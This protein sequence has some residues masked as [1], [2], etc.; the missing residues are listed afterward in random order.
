MRKKTILFVLL[1]SIFLSGCPS[2]PSEQSEQQ[3][4]TDVCIALCQQAVAEA[5]DLSDGPCLSNEAIEDWV[6]D[7]AHSP[8][9]DIDNLPE[10]QCSAFRDKTAN[11]FV[12][13]DESCKVIQF[14]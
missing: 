6:C 13:L 5:R 4:A 11:H 3:Q 10:N 9:Q 7:I 1:A 12:E 8:R 14:Y 2:S